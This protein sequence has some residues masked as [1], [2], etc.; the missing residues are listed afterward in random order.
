MRHALAFIIATPAI[1]FSEVKPLDSLPP[2]RLL[3][4]VS[5]EEE[6][7]TIQLPDGYRLELV[8]SEPDITEPTAMAFDGNGRMYVVEMR[9]GV[10]DH[11]ECRR[12]GD[13]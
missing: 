8:L 2:A 6:L 4:A 3:P 13:R 9:I 7:T 10:C 1:V 11:Q 5:A 12:E